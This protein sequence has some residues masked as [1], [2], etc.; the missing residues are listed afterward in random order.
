VSPDRLDP[1]YVER[2]ARMRLE[3]LA[4]FLQLPSAAAARMA[5]RRAGLVPMRVGRTV[6][7]SRLD[8]ERAFGLTR[9]R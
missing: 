6:L 8:V 7:F 9:R 2:L 4:V 3:Q 1:E 5:A